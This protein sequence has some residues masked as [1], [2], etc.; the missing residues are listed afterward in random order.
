[1]TEPTNPLERLRQVAFDPEVLVEKPEIIRLAGQCKV[2]NLNGLILE[3]QQIASAYRKMA[4]RIGDVERL[5]S[6]DIRRRAEA[7]DS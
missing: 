2:H 3:F 7:L 1:M 6:D 5:V 4:Y